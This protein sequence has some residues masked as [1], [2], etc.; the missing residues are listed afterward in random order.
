MANISHLSQLEQLFKVPAYTQ[1]TNPVTITLH[2][3]L[4]MTAYGKLILHR[5]RMPT[6]WALELDPLART[7]HYSYVHPRKMC[8]IHNMELTVLQL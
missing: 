1:R 7:F 4:P 8:A 2:D 3:T 6:M 5:H